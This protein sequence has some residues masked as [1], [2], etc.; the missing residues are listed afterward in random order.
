VESEKRLQGPKSP[1]ATLPP[2]NFLPQSPNAGASTA[3][4]LERTH[5][6]FRPW[7]LY[8]RFLWVQAGADEACETKALAGASGKLTRWRFGLAPARIKLA[9]ARHS[10]NFQDFSGLGGFPPLRE[11]LVGSGRRG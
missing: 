11:V 3:R 9:K 10:N 2:E 7:R 5:E 6:A 4:K 8:V 1:A